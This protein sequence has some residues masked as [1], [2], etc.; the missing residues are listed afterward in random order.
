VD[1]ELTTRRRTLERVRAR[2]D[3]GSAIAEPADPVRSS[4]LR[5]ATQP[6]LPEDKSEA[7][8]DDPDTVA[9]RWEA[10]PIRL[11]W[12]GVAD[13]LRAIAE[14][15]DLVAAVT[16]ETGRILWSWG[17]RHM[18]DRAEQVNFGL[19]GRWDES[20]VG[21][22]AIALALISG[23]PSTVFAVEHWCAAVHDWVCYSAPIRDAHGNN[24][25]VIDLST[26]WDHANPLGMPTINAL[27]RVIEQQTRQ[28]PLTGVRAAA[29]A[30]G[31]ILR[32]RVLG[33]GEVTLGGVPLLLTPRQLEILT[34]LACVRETSLNELHA[35]LHGDRS[36]STTTT[37]V[38]IS[39]LR[40]V[41]GGN[42][43]GSRPYRLMVPVDCDLADLLDHLDMG[44]VAGAT[45]LYGGRLLAQSE[46]PFIVERRH[47][48]DVA[49]RT[50][51]LRHGTTP[52][53]LVFADV[54]A[55]DVEVLERAITRAHPDDPI[56][57]G[58]TA[59]LAVALDQHLG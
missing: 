45:A 40:R 39:Q 36:V 28:V 12:P 37:K 50:A 57:P 3:P 24:L 53:L 5:C 17:G 15:G 7:P 13:E 44:D 49:L 21:T 8:L 20:S 34:I 9:D 38:E 22:N 26:T 32:L 58:A 47:H 59:R 56:I 16:D 14:A 29:L 25:G 18:R 19:G 54:H 6:Q 41:V 30:G 46:S 52:Q 35:L 27:A 42:V 23:Q 55:H 10:S 51:L 4:W 33:R 48:C 11:A 43:I 1:Q 2:F 31:P